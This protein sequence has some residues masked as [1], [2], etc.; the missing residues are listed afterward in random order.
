MV[1]MEPIRLG[2]VEMFVA[3]LE[4]D[5][6]P[7][8]LF[9]AL[10]REVDGNSVRLLDFA[11]VC[12]TDHGLTIVEADTDELALLGLPLIAPGLVAEE[13]MRRVS[14]SVPPGRCAAVFLIEL[15]WARRLSATIALGGAVIV[16]TRRFPAV[17]VNAI[18]DLVLDDE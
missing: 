1:A 5:H 17:V 10:V 18:L 13:D 4:G 9:D 12:N 16:E 7:P 8:A 3:V 14:P 2:P 15:E 6:P 11:T